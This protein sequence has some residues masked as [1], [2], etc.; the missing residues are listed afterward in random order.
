[1]ET[2]SKNNVRFIDV[3]LGIENQKS[4]LNCT[5]IFCMPLNLKKD[6]PLSNVK[7][8]LDRLKNDLVFSKC[9]KM[10]K[11]CKPLNFWVDF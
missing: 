2:H 7:I 10:T 11:N 9:I 6:V 3:L 4:I 1:M 5:G 8:N